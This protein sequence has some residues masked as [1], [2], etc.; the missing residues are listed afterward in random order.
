MGKH[1][2]EPRTPIGHDKVGDEPEH[3]LRRPGRAREEEHVEPRHHERE[4]GR[5]A[6]RR[7]PSCRAGPAPPYRRARRP[8][9]ARA[10]LSFLGL[11]E[12][13]TCR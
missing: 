8:G 5:A 4:I 9:R 13:R 7:N 11:A 3:E 10:T 6:D 12:V 1:Q 2:A